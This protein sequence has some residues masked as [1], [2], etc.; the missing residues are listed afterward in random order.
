[1]SYNLSYSNKNLRNSQATSNMKGDNLNSTAS[2]VATF[3]DDGK[4]IQSYQ[5]QMTL[6]DNKMIGDAN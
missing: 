1:M 2:S 3:L 5:N 4:S 6:S